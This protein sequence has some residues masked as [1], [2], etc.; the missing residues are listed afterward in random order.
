MRVLVTGGAG[1]IGGHTA[2]L[3]LR[4]GDDVVVVDNMNTYYDPAIK[5]RCL[6]CLKQTASTCTG[7][8]TIKLIDFRN[9]AELEKIFQEAVPDAVCHLGA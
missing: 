8:L 9:K 3:L 2:E 4:R 5:E 7:K 6:E 1:F